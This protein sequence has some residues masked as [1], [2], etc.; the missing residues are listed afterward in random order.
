MICW[1]KKW[2]RLGWFHGGV[3]NLALQHPFTM[4]DYQK[5]WQQLIFVVKMKEI[6]EGDG[7]ITGD[8]QCIL[9][10]SPLLTRKWRKII[11]SNT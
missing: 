11:M 1:Y 9:P 3:H 5:D 6:F 8:Y 7:V 4:Q 2:L 10:L